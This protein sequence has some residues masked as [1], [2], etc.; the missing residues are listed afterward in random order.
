MADYLTA[1]LGNEGEQ[2]ITVIPQPV[3]EL[4][5][6]GLAEGLFI[7]LAY[8]F[9]IIRPFV[10]NNDSIHFI[11][12]FRLIEQD[13]AL[14]VKSNGPPPDASREWPKFTR[15]SRWSCAPL[16]AAQPF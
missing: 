8:R 9:Y 10:P 14:P 4:G 6:I 12:P 15:V 5:L 7:H 16:P 3:H 11:T 1:A 2:G 13:G